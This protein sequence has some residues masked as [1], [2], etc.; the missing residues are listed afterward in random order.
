MFKKVFPWSRDDQ[1]ELPV[2]DEKGDK[3]HIREK[4]VEDISDEY[5]WR[6]D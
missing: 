1:K 4:R 2:V 6:V 5:A 3:V